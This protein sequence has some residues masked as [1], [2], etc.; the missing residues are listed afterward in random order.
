MLSSLVSDPGRGKQFPE[1][2][3][4]NLE[5][6]GWSAKEKASYYTSDGLYGFINGGAEIF[7]QYGF[8]NLT[9]CPYRPDRGP[10]TAEIVLEIYQMRTPL[11]AFGIFSI[12][13]G[14]QEAASA[15]I[16]ALNWVSDT[17][18]NLVKDTFFIN[19]LGFECEPRDLE[20]FAAVVAAKISGD[21]Y[22]PE[23]FD[24]FPESGRIAGSGKYLQGPLSAAGESVL[25]RSDFWG[26]S[27]GTT[28]WAMRYSP[29]HIRLILLELKN[30]PAEFMAG[31]SA[32]FREF[33]EDVKVD[34][35]EVWG[36][37]AMGSIFLFR[38]HGSRA[39]LCL[40]EESLAAARI[41]LERILE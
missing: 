14:S 13:R 16:K 24:R 18:V 9:V 20:A 31:V 10:G 33:L 8:R 39:G 25:L 19:I 7:L 4:E 23:I 35:N 36:K 2:H 28:G 1:L 3:P 5:I 15:E 37:N 30:I 29:S 27:R 22:R 12:K 26:F 17:Q 6:P 40:G 38:L 34:Q 32:R 41:K 11:E 21:A